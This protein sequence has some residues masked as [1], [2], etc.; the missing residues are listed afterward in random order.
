MSTEVVVSRDDG[1]LEI[2]LDKPK[3]NVLDRALMAE[4]SAALAAH[5]EAPDL[6]VVLLSAAG[7]HFSF[8]ASVEEHRPATVGPM[9]SAFHAL[10]RQVAAYPVPIVVVVQGSC[11]G[12]AFELV[13]AC[14]DVLVTANASLGCPE[15]RLGVFP[16]VLAVL[17]AQRVGGAVAERLLLTGQT[18]T[19]SEAVACGLAA[20]IVPLESPPE[21]STPAP[22]AEPRRSVQAYVRQYTSLSG[23]AVRHAVAAIRRPLVASLGAPLDEAERHYLDRLM[24]GSDPVEG[25]DAFLARRAPSWSHA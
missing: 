1:C 16:P 6:R 13:L 14:H 23:Y 4:L 5:A 20:A 3:G 10:I 7:P 21:D 19:A 25:I 12:G 9:L 15:L 18:L 2:V 11:L 22:R 17:G 24:A 8:G